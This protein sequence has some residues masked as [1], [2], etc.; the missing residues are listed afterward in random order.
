VKSDARSD[1][2]ARCIARYPFLGVIERDVVDRRG[3]AFVAVTLDLEPWSIVTARTRE[4]H[5]L[6]VEQHRY[7]ID[8]STLEP[9]GGI[10]DE[11]ETP[12]DAARRE[13]LEETGYGGGIVHD[14]GWV[15]PNPALGNNRAFLFWIEGVERVASPS[16]PDDD[17]E[18][19][20]A[21]DELGLVQAIAS[22]RISHALGVLALERALVIAR[23]QG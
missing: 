21:L 7:G 22:G 10:V 16:M 2:S 13:L 8:A 4:G 5:W 11:G 14:L 17:I 15:H 6:F 1:G 23:S 3:R 12:S 19:V 20:V 9:A 18:R